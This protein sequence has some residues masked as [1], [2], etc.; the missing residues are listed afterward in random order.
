[1]VSFYT[2][3][4]F[5]AI[6]TMG[7]FNASLEKKKVVFIMGATGTGKS[8]LS[9]E[10]AAKFE[11]EIINSDKMQVYKGLDI[12][13]NKLTKSEQQGIKHHL[14]SKFDPHSDFNA[15]DF[16]FHA[17]TAIKRI[18][19]SGRVPIVVGGSNSFVEEL[20]ES[21]FFNFRSRFDC[22][23][24]WLDVSLPLLYSFVSKRVDLM[25]DSG[26]V[27]SHS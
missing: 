13:T 19:R 8:K 14:L 25:V 5:P 12:V 17:V 24:I 18:L 11:G 1:M 7:F 10:I 20:V 2:V 22:C 6:I 9:V 4:F 3:L 16:C 21:S 23:F 27:I 15:T 26:V